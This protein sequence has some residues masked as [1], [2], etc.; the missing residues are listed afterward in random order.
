MSAGYGSSDRST[1]IRELN[2]RK[3]DMK[4]AMAIDMAEV[5]F[6]RSDSDAPYK[7]WVSFKSGKQQLVSKNEADAIIDLLAK[8]DR[9][10][11]VYR[12]GEK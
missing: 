1:A 3:N 10:I 11:L 2:Q 7:N 5:E 4:T 6:V 9:R 12:K 8:G